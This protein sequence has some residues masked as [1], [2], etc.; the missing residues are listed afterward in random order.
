MQ[1]AFSEI[2]FYKKTFNVVWELCFSKIFLRIVTR[3]QTVTPPQ[4]L[5]SSNLYSLEE[6]SIK[7]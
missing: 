6:P 2:T 1:L 5:F 7:N 3:I 4:Y